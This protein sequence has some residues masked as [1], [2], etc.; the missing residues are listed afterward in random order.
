MDIAGVS[1]DHPESFL[2]ILLNFVI[3]NFSYFLSFFIWIYYLINPCLLSLPFIVYFF[4]FE[5]IS[6]RKLTAFMLLYIFSIIVLSL[7]VQI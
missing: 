4:S 6:D 5:I 1:S 7:M 3:S 2:K